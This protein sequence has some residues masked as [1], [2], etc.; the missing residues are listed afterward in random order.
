[1]SFKKAADVESEINQIDQ[2]SSVS[3][4]PNKDFENKT[5]GFGRHNKFSKKNKNKQTKYGW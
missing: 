3:N 1:L 5:A 4:Q 2:W